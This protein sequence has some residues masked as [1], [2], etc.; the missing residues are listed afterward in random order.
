M[1]L[2][3]DDLWHFTVRGAIPA[4]L[5]KSDAQNQTVVAASAAAHRAERT[6]SARLKAGRRH[7]AASTTVTPV[8]PGRIT[9][10]EVSQLTRSVRKHA[11]E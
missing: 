3:T 4:F 9:V 10:L 5:P 2:H 8:A 1:H 11:S 7:S 6:D